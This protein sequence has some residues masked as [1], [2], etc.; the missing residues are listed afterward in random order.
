[1]VERSGR[2]RLVAASGLLCAGIILGTSAVSVSARPVVVLEQTAPGA[3][4]ATAATVGSGAGS[5][6]SVSGDGRFVA[7]QGAPATDDDPRTTTVYLTDRES[8]T[9]EEM[10]VEVEIE[11]EEARVP[12]E[13]EDVA[14][15]VDKLHNTA[16]VI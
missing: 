14:D 11:A 3:T 10:T 13:V 4:E 5:H 2:R 6:A 9:T 1:V 15:L 16:K 7:S 8:G 12:A